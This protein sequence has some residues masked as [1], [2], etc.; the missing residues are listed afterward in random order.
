[1]PLA[2]ALALF[3]RLGINVECMNQ[4]GS[5]LILSLYAG[6]RGGAKK[7][8]RAAG[9][10]ICSLTPGGAGRGFWAAKPG[11]CGISTRLILFLG[12]GDVAGLLYDGQASYAFDFL[13]PCRAFPHIGG[14]IPSF[15]A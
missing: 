9:C 14:L 13:N 12:A 7:P 4:N 1:M 6:A 5:A 2:D 8:A 11:F 15:S 3:R 10:L